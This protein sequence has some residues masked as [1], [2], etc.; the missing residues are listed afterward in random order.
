MMWMKIL[1]T[2]RLVYVKCT[3]TI[4]VGLFPEWYKGPVVGS[5]G[6]WVGTSVGTSADKH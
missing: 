1:I 4:S 6:A 3:P 5:A 2:A